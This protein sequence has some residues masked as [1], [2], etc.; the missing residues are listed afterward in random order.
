MKKLLLL[1]LPFLIACNFT[2]EE[3]TKVE[4]VETTTEVAEITT[5]YLIRHAEKDRSNAEEKDPELTIEGMERANNW[6]AVFKD[7]EF[8]AIYSTN[9]KRTMETAAP[10]A[11]I[12]ELEIKNYDP[13]DL[14]NSEFQKNTLGKTVL[15]VGHSNT[16]PAFVNKI[17]G[18]EKFEDIQD[19]ENGALFIVSV[20]PDLEPSVQLLH[21]N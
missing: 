7:V 14:Y 18:K 9:Y 1:V 13:N 2:N 6:L 20:V 15:V 8:D 21:I 19:D 10:T 3:E 11:N 12:K 16:T 4:P 17:L 5:Y